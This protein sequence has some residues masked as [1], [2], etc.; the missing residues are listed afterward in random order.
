M[1]WE[2]NGEA[3]MI[4]KGEEDLKCLKIKGVRRIRRKMELKKAKLHMMTS[5]NE[6]IKASQRNH[7]WF[8]SP[9]AKRSQT[10]PC[11]F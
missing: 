8:Q 11:I 2:A 7:A 1:H 10:N 5:S 9:Y 6:W 3:R 4:K